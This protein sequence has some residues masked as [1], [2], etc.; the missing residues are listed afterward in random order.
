MEQ[1]QSN[2]TTSLPDM[3]P[4]SRGCTLFTLHQ[5]PCFLRNTSPAAVLPR[6]TEDETQDTHDSHS[7]SP[8]LSQ[9]TRPRKHS[10]PGEMR[11]ASGTEPCGQLPRASGVEEDDRTSDEVGR[12]LHRRANS[13]NQS[14]LSL[15]AR[16]PFFLVQSRSPIPVVVQWLLIALRARFSPRNS[17]GQSDHRITGDG[18]LKNR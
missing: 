16:D 14:A 10:N 9:T 7:P 15:N 12:P 8:H 17:G 3:L 18:T 13:G 5:I 4:F 2:R 11:S 6:E 1:L